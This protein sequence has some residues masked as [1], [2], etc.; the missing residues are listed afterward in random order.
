MKNSLLIIVLALFI[1]GCGHEFYIKQSKK[2]Y[3]KAISKGYKPRYDSIPKI[4]LVNNIRLGFNP[5]MQ[6]IIDR[7]ID[8]LLLEWCNKRVLDPSLPPP[9]IQIKTIYDSAFKSIKIDTLI[10]LDNGSNARIMIEN[11]SAIFEIITY[12]IEEKIYMPVPWYGDKKVFFGLLLI[13]ALLTFII[14]RIR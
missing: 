10:K 8:T 9:T 11:G 1:S 4:T 3:E 14:L 12:C 6:P 7:K 13:I 2:S 5:K